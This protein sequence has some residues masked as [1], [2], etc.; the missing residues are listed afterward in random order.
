MLKY[1]L[2]KP[3]AI[4]SL[5]NWVNG[6]GCLAR[7]ET[8]YLE[9]NNELIRVHTSDDGAIERLETWIDN[10]LIQIYNLFGKVSCAKA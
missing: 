5:Q 2:A 4:L 9:Q 1:E 8:A 7:E 6:N 10:K 3:K